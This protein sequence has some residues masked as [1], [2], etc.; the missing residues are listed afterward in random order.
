[1]CINFKTSIGAFAIGT[2][3]GL[4]LITSENK[5][6]IAIGACI[7][8]YTL[9]QLCEALIYNNNLE[10][11]SKIL[12]LILGFQG[13]VFA[14][15][16]NTI[17]PIH[18]FFIYAFVFIAGVVL[19]KI[20]QPD[21][22]KATIEG[23]MKWNFKDDFTNFAL[24]MM[25]ILIFLIV[26]LYRNKFDIFNKFTILMLVLYVTSQLLVMVYPKLL[27][28]TNKPSIWCLASAVASPIMLY[29]K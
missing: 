4:L 17:T 15:F 16:L 11:Y 20:S 10:I 13:L 19:Y 29:F 28:S 9:V 23:G 26:Y 2:I 22:K 18:E 12:L 6:K 8:F 14:I 25:Y 7:M 24:T 3:A 5:E 1:M 27:C 21:F